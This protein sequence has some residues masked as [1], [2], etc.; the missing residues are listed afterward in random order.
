MLSNLLH[1]QKNQ[2]GNK[3]YTNI[4]RKQQKMNKP[5]TIL[6]NPL[7]WESIFHVKIEDLLDKTYIIPHPKTHSIKCFKPKQLLEYI[8][9]FL[10]TDWENV[11]N[12]LTCEDHNSKIQNIIKA[13]DNNLSITEDSEKA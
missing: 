8:D 11:S 5:N 3:I 1:L 7:N 13:T 2:N 10:D 12:L 6:N 9:S 4:L